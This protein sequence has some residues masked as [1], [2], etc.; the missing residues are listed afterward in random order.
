MLALKTRVLLLGV[1]YQS[2]TSHHFAEWLC[3]V[4]YRHTIDLQIKVKRADGTIV[5]QTM[6]DHQP[7]SYVGTQHS[8]FNRLGQLLEEQGHGDRGGDRKLSK[9]LLQKEHVYHNRG[10]GDYNILYLVDVRQVTSPLSEA[11]DYYDTEVDRLEFKECHV[12]PYSAAQETFEWEWKTYNLEIP[13]ADNVVVI[14]QR[15]PAN[16]GN[17]RRHEPAEQGAGGK[18]GWRF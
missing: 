2:S 11:I 1:D 5:E 18:G 14:S 3:E 10:S 13:E 12:D 7:F 4:P 6:V 17:I 8:D 15:F 16:D 9:R